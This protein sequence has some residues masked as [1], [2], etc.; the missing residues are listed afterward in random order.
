MLPGHP[1][2]M[3]FK[4]G[5][6][7]LFDELIQTAVA[8]MGVNP[9]K[10]YLMGYSAGG[11]GVYRLAPRMAD[12]WAAAAM[13]A[14]HPGEVSMLNLRNT[15]FTLWM[16]ELDAAYDRNR[17]AV[18]RGLE[19]DSLHRADPGGYI[20][21]THIVRGKGHWMERQDSVAVEWMAQYRRNPLPD[22]IV[23][24]QENVVHP[25]FYWLAVPKDECVPGA[26][27][28]VERQ[29]NQFDIKTCDYKKLTIRLNDKLADLDQPVSVTYQGKV[30]YQ[31]K[32][33]RTI[34]TLYRTLGERGD[35]GLFFCSEITVNL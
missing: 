30:L 13:M 31:E 27:V 12:R 10:V 20:H 1:G 16:G 14:G 5:I 3:W 11:D 23:W 4:P 32:P 2:N 34:R 6:D 7:S 28:V 18:E 8:V 33:E 9:D 24:R 17:M 15:P 26:M 22:R 25:S 29:G 35:K 21:E 19:L